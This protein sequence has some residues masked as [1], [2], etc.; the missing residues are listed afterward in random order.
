MLVQIVNSCFAE[1]NEKTH[2][3]FAITSN[4]LQFVKSYIFHKHVLH[5]QNIVN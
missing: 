5:F 1:I 3:L 2:T 4:S